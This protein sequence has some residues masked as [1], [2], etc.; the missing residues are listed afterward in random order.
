MVNGTSAQTFTLNVLEEKYMID[1][2]SMT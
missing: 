2:Y 1:I